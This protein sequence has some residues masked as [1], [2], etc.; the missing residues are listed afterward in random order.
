MNDLGEE[1]KGRKD[2]CAVRTDAIRASSLQGGASGRK[3]Y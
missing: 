1:R 2:K 3:R